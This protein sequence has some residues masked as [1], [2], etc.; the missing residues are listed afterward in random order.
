MAIWT[1]DGVQALCVFAADGPAQAEAEAWTAALSGLP[2]A[3]VQ[4]GG[5]AVAVSSERHRSGS[6]P[7]TAL[8]ARWVGATDLARPTMVCV[9]VPPD[10]RSADPTVEPLADQVVSMLAETC[11]AP[12]PRAF[13]VLV[14]AVDV[15]GSADAVARLVVHDRTGVRPLALTARWERADRDRMVQQWVDATCLIGRVGMLQW[16]A[17]E[18]GYFP[19]KVKGTV[20]GSLKATSTE[21]IWRWTKTADAWPDAFDV[22]ARVKGKQPDGEVSQIAANTDLNKKTDHTPTVADG[23]TVY[24]AVDADDNPLYMIRS[25]GTLRYYAHDKWVPTNGKRLKV[26]AEKIAFSTTTTT[27]GKGDWWTDQ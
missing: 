21:E 16:P 8:I 14:A 9:F 10:A 17:D 1:A 20:V 7:L 27:P 26:P 15:A 5:P 3:Q 13:S 12:L 18:N 25:T 24:K 6:D 22:T 2:G 19:I 4:L 11:R 23:E